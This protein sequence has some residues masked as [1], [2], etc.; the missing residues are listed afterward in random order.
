MQFT[1]HDREETLSLGETLGKSLIPGDIV[2]LFGDLGS[3]KTTL[4]QGISQGLGLARGEYVRSP[5]F[6]IINE[7][8]GSCPIYHVDLYRLESFEEIEALGLEEVLFGDGVSV[9]EWSEKLYIARE[10]KNFLGLGIEEFLEIRIQI[11]N[12][13]RRGFDVKPR[14]LNQRNFRIFSLQ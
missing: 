14:F 7:Y 9:V 11:L 13:S 1:T 3:G 2:L 8:Q 10:G 6:T 5:T 12:E 4:T